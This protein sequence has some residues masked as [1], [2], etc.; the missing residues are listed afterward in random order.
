M[1]L[2]YKPDPALCCGAQGPSILSFRLW[3]FPHSGHNE[4]FSELQCDCVIHN[5][6]Y[7]IGLH[8]VT[9][10][11]LKPSEFPHQEKSYKGAFVM[12]I[13]DFRKA[14]KSPKGEGWSPEEPTM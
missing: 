13:D 3:Y 2:E 4:L 7:I 6:E 8:P 11:V 1:I 12:L 14:P 9:G 5:K 10:R